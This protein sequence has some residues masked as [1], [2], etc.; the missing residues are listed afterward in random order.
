MGASYT[1]LAKLFVMCNMRQAAIVI[2]N[3]ICKSFLTVMDKGVKSVIC[4]YK[5]TLLLYPVL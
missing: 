5:Q 1:V 4:K 2:Y 3:E